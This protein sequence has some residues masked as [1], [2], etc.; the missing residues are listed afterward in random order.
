MV[1]GAVLIS[2]GLAAVAG[3]AGHVL[4]IAGLAVILE[5]QFDLYFPA[6]LARLTPR[7]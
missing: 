2:L 3:L 6:K 4:A 1:A 7:E 5:A